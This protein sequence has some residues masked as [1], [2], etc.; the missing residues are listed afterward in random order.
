MRKT[1]VIVVVL[2]M[3]SLNGLAQKSGTIS[4]AEPDR[5]AQRMTPSI[6]GES[7]GTVSKSKLLGADRIMVN[8]TVTVI[9]YDF[10]MTYA[11]VKTYLTVQG[12]QL[13]S[14]VRHYI[15]T[16]RPSQIIRFK[17]ILCKDRN[18]LMFRVY[19]MQFQ[20]YSGKD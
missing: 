2:L 3:S 18:G 6:A 16:S 20:M 5:P 11:S 9:S 12:N 7:G 1:I 13:T 14:D 8:D 15:D 17:N 19:D 10:S 4:I